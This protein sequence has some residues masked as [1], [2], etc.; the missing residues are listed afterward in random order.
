M[1]SGSQF[2][3]TELTLILSKEAKIPKFIALNVKNNIRNVSHLHS[4]V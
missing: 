1:L 3:S 2:C 4:F